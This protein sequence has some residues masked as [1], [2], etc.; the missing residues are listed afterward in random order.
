MSR[1]ITT[2][3]GLNRNVKVNLKMVYADPLIKMKK[4]VDAYTGI[5]PGLDKNG[6]PVTGLTEDYNEPSSKSGAIPKKIPGTREAMEKLIDVPA[7]TLKQ[8]SSYWHNFFIRLGSDAI[9]LDLRSPHDLLKYLFC[10]GQSNVA[11]GLNKVEEHSGIEFVLYS[12]EQEAAERIKGRRSLKDAYNLAEKLDLETK[13]QIL[14]TYGI[15]VDAT[16]PNSIIDKI[17]EKIEE[18]PDTF[19][20]KAKDDYLVVKSLL[21]H[22]LDKGILIME[23]GAIKH[24]EVVVGHTRNLAAQAIA[25]DKT[26]ETILRAKLSGDMDLIKNALSNDDIKA[27]H[28]K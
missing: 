5:G 28:K 4:Y 9:E 25:S 16:N 7:G 6:F 23:D 3:E 19:L 26:L 24:G 1:K 14:A 10:L 17:D 15:V 12:E 11:D 21:T 8:T 27:S 18:D 22:A 2:L 13:M 20:K